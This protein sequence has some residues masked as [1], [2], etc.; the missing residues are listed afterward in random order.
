MEDLRIIICVNEVDA[1]AERARCQA[2]LQGANVR[3]VKR[4]IQDLP[5]MP[6]VSCKQGSFTYSVQVS[7]NVLESW[8]VCT[9]AV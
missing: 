1:E 9:E 8:V 3:V 7:N 6:P 5:L 4:R 2:A